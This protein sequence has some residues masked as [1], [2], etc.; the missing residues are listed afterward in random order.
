MTG[1]LLLNGEP[2]T[3]H[4]VHHLV[5]FVPQAD[6][7]HGD[8]TVYENLAFAASLRLPSG[9]SNVRAPEPVHGHT[10]AATLDHRVR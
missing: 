9:T 3:V 2:M 5:G 10:T 7:V 1:S 6:T 8:L 4:S